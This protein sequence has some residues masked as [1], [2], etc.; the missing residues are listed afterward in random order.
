ME[1][2]QRLRGQRALAFQQCTQGTHA[3]GHVGSI[4][5][6]LVGLARPHHVTG[7][8]CD[9]AQVFQRQA[10]QRAAAGA[11]RFGHIGA[12][13]LVG[14]VQRQPVF[15]KRV[16]HLLAQRLAH[17]LDALR[18]DGVEF[19]RD[20]QLIRQGQHQ[21]LEGGIQR[22]V[23][24]HGTQGF[25]RGG[26]QDL[27]RRLGGLHGGHGLRHHQALGSFP[28]VEGVAVMRQAVQLGGF[29]FA[30]QLQPDGCRELAQQ[31]GHRFF[32]DAGEGEAG[33]CIIQYQYPFQQGRRGITL[34][35]QRQGLAAT[36]DQAHA[37][38]NQEGLLGRLIGRGWAGLTQRQRAG[39][40]SGIV[41]A[42]GMQRGRAGLAVP[43]LE[44]VE[45]ACQGAV[46]IGIG[47]G[48]GKVVAGYG[49]A[50][51]TLEVQVHA[52][53][54]A[55]A[56]HQRLVHAYH[57]GAF[58]VDGGGVEIGD[59]LVLVG[60]YRMGHGAGILAELHGAQAAHV[61]DAAD[62]ARTRAA[63]QILAEFL[64]A[65]YRQAFLQAQLK[66]VA[67]GDAV[68]G[69][70]VEVL[71]PDH[72]GDAVIVLIGGGG[73]LGQHV[74]G[75]EDIQALVLH[76][77][78]VEVAGGHDHEALQIQRQAKTGFVPG[79]AL[80]QRLHGV[81]GLVQVAGAHEH[82]QQ[83]LLAATADDALLACHQLGC[84]QREQVAR[85]PERVVPDGEVA[86]IFQLALFQQVAVGKQHRIRLF[87][88]AQRDLVGGH[89][90]GAIQE[91][92]D[93]AEA[94]R[95]ALRE[96]TAFAGVQAHQLGVLAGVAGGEDLQ[97][98][99]LAAFGQVLQHQL[100]AFQL[101]GRAL[102][103]DQHTRQ[104]QLLAIQA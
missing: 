40:R 35:L 57:L 92:G 84:H 83:V 42:A 72:A 98:D 25:Q 28:A 21:L 71:M 34:Q 67:A 86:A 88:G 44:Y 69:P 29:V 1:A 37:Y 2:L 51:M 103:V 43:A 70:V 93:A 75:V 87:V 80:Q 11:D 14:L 52:L 30:L 58:F 53:A 79:D 36:A 77:A 18:I 68:A 101:E 12:G 102:A 5:E 49:L 63:G 89:H 20:F 97:R 26:I 19:F 45:A 23:A 3:V 22:R 50:V 31:R 90:V 10:G 76:G 66:P 4:L 91:V 16:C 13:I 27:C 15:G 81:F 56:A 74:L 104:V 46:R 33:F 8:A 78:G 99:R 96:E 55:V 64:V 39:L 95:L 73:R 65:E 82:L 62:G 41:A 17:Q 54:E 60:A 24:Q 9:A 38:R 100:A 48:L 47:H 85:L 59:F 6:A 61:A 32:G 94:L 7:I